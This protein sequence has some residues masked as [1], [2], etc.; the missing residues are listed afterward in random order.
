M[1]INK[2]QISFILCIGLLFFLFAC[3]EGSDA[4]PEQ[5]SNGQ[6]GSLASFSISKNHLYIINGERINFYDIQDP[7]DPKPA[8]SEFVG[9]GLETLFSTANN[10]FIGS[11]TGMH[12]FDITNPTFPE[13]LSTYSHVT[14]CD[15]VV[16]KGQYAYVTIR[17]G[18]D[19][20]FGENL[21]DVVDI[22]DLRAPRVVASIPMSNPHGLGADGNS[23]FVCEGEFGL[24]TFDISEPRLPAQRQHFTDFHSFDVIPNNGNLIVIGEDGLY[25]YDYQDENSLQLLS[26]IITQ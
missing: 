3:E 22:S 6:A 24:K 2:S 21:L 15:P 11:Q 20:R 8:G 17:D 12:I 9:S 13:W 25:Q 14:A 4:G 10:L 7:R 5:P 1:Y 16:V 26:K 18:V 23:L 19:C